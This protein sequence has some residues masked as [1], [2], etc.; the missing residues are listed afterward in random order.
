MNDPDGLSSR[1]NPFI[2]V[3]REAADMTAAQSRIAR[4][5]LINQSR[6]RAHPRGHPGSARVHADCNGLQ[7]YDRQFGCTFQCIVQDSVYATPHLG[8]ST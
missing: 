3:H 4:A 5:E 7:L 1:L 6:G 8:R 2:F